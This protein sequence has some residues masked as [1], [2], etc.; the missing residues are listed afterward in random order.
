MKPNCAKFFASGGASSG[1]PSP[2]GGG[3]L[4]DSAALPC[5]ATLAKSRGGFAASYPVLT[6]NCNWM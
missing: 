3:H 4:G 1:A 6:D 5:Q 2:A